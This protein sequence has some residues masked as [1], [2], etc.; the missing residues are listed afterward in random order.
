MQYALWRFARGAWVLA[1]L[2]NPCPGQNDNRFGV[3]GRPRPRFTLDIAWDSGRRRGGFTT[4]QTLSPKRGAAVDRRR[5]V[6]A[7]W[8]TTRDLWFSMRATPRTWTR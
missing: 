1:P 4:R 8:P 7:C 2:G 6:G 5:S 3:R